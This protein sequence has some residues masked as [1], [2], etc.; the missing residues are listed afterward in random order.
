MRSETP[1]IENRRQLESAL[2]L[3]TERLS[4]QFG[5]VL[6]VPNGDELDVVYEHDADAIFTAASVIKLPIA[7][8]F[9]HAVE[10]GD[11]PDCSNPHPIAPENRVGGSGLLSLLDGTPTQGDLLRAMLAISDNAATNELID[12]LGM[13]VVNDASSRLGMNRTNLGRKMMATLEGDEDDEDG[14]SNDPINTTSPRDCVRFFVDFHREITLSAESY[15]AMREP[16]VRAESTFGRYLPYETTIANKTGW[17][18]TAALD[19]GLLYA[20]D[21]SPLAFAVA[22]DRVSHGAD[23]ADLIAEVGA[24]AYAWFTR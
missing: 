2:D 15:R 7:H 24:A 3:L 11:L 22:T 8:A 6:A 21:R 23:G 18:P 10:T 20:P 16:L 1:T 17:L 13:D 5:V 4:G 14:D 12:L 9:Y 19:T